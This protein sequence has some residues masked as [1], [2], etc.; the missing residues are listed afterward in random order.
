MIVEK[1]G[2]LTY[3]DERLKLYAKAEKI[4]IEEVALFPLMYGQIELLVK[5]SMKKFS[6]SHLSDWA[7]NDIW[8]ERLLPNPENEVGLSL[9]VWHFFRTL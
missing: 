8:V 7:F 6:I 4:L 3:Q 1:A 2:R 5:P 9:R